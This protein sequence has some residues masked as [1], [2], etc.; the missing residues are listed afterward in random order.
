MN[1]Q[2][3]IEK[4]VSVRTFNENR[5]IPQSD[6]A[7]LEQAIASV[8]TPFK[9]DYKIELKKFDLKGPQ[10]PSTYGTISG[11]SWYLLM[12]IADNELSAL[13]AG[14][15]M[16]EVV[17]KATELGLGTCWMAL[18]FKGSDFAKEAQF[19]DA[20]PLKIISPVGYAAEKRRFMESITRMSLGSSKRK[21]MKDLFSEAEFGKEVA[22]DNV[23]YK[24]LE[25]MRLAPSAK[26]TQPWRALVEGNSIWFYYITKTEAAVLDLGIG[27]SH[28]ELTMKAEG[29]TGIWSDAKYA[30]M[31]EDYKPM[32]KYTLQ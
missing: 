7:T 4:R 17:L 20:T 1:I 13:A 9:G 23:F 5:T 25:M 6:I 29:K 22:E 30:P 15:A 16:E 2:D 18:T 26:N 32:V 3:I 8:K 14:Y 31:H 27:L 12:G 10:S 11:A 21:K 19:D 24:A 28:F